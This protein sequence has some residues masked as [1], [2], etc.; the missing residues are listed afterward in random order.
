MIANNVGHGVAV[1]LYSNDNSIQDGLI[2]GN[3]R[4]GF[5]VDGTGSYGNAVLDQ[6][7][8]TANTGKGIALTNGANAG[9]LPPVIASVSGGGTQLTVSG[10][11]LPNAI[12]NIYSDPADEGATYLAN[13]TAAPDGTWSNSTW[14][15]RDMTALNTA[16]KA[17]QITIRAIQRDA[18]SNSSEFSGTVPL[19]T[20]VSGI[21]RCGETLMPGAKVTVYSGTAAVASTVTDSTAAYQIAGLGV[22]SYTVTFTLGY[23]ICGGPFVVDAS[24]GVTMSFATSPIDLHNH[25]WTKAYRLDPS[26]AT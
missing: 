7:K 20:L 23:K 5:N 14:G 21:A 1:N 17:G 8:I 13:V 19:L 15:V 2:A 16:L 9:I 12:V 6:A 10:T 24:G 18:N 22:G 26:F 11:A 25:A 4:D 3:G